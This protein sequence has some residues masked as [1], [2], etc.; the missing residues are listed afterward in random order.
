LIWSIKLGSGAQVAS[1][2][3]AETEMM[4]FVQRRQ[5]MWLFELRTVVS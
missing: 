2:L 5:L 3:T 1:K 4:T